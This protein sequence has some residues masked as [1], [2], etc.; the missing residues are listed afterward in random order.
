MGR[1]AGSVVAVADSADV[2][3]LDGKVKTMEPVG[4]VSRGSNS[5][6][7]RRFLWPFKAEYRVLYVNDTYDQTVIGRSKRDYLWIMARTP[8]LSADDYSALVALVEQQGYDIGKIRKVPH[9]P[10]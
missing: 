4:F 8:T 3:K 10:Q 7:G 9:N 5:V 1:S 2:D 6:W